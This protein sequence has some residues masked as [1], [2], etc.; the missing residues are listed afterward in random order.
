MYCLNLV[1]KGS[2]HRSKLVIT[3]TMIILIILIMVIMI[4]MLI[5]TLVK[6]MTVNAARKQE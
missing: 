4:A 5:E 6:I 3:A 1:N 2:Y